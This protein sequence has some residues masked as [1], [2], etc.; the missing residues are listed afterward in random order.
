MPNRRRGI[1]IRRVW[2]LSTVTLLTLTVGVVMMLRSQ[3]MGILGALDADG[4]RAALLQRDIQG[5][6]QAMLNQEVGL[7]GFLATGDD[8]FLEP[9]RNGR[10]DELRLR[11]T[12]VVDDLAAEDRDELAHALLLEARAARRWHD[13]IAEPQI[14]WR[15]NAVDPGVPVLLQEGKQ[16]F[17]A[18]RASYGTLDQALERACMNL[19]RRQRAHLQAANKIAVGLLVLLVVA[20]AFISRA[21]LR[22]TIAPLTALCDAAERGEVSVEAVG[23]S[24]L[25]EVL[26][27]ASTLEQLFR[28]V[29]D[30]AMRD[31]LTRVYNRAYLAEVLP[32]Q[33]RLARRNGAPVAALMVDVD[34]FKR[35]NDT[36]GHA[37]GDKVLVAMA[38]C[39]EQQLRAS[40]VVVRYGGEEFTVILPDTPIAGAFV[41]AERLRAAI[42][43]MTDRDGLPEGLRITASIGVAAALKGDDGAQ[44]LP[45]ADAA[46]YQ[47]KRGGRNRVVA[48]PMARPLVTVEGERLAG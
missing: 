21:I 15:R 45:R 20:G 40:D 6:M 33:L 11:Q 38:R 46:L 10:R 1:S 48:A 34:H 16:R 42:A 26:V 3:M 2:M 39:I 7:R 41:T 14:A 32:R 22:R 30:R 19:Q 24:K 4:D 43:A 47:A 31:G 9:Y 8:S 12:F 28:G 35:I 37:A 25:R 27:L 18:Y 23:T 17:D 5:R 13:E 44:L 36:L 29:Q